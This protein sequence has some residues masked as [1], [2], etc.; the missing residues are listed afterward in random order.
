[1]DIIKKRYTHRQHS[2]PTYMNRT[3]AHSHRNPC[4][5]HTYNTDPLAHG[6]NTCTNP[7][8]PTRKHK[9]NT[10]NT[11]SLPSPP[12]HYTANTYTYALHTYTTYKHTHT[13]HTN[14]TTRLPSPRHT[15]ATA[16]QTQRNPHAKYS[17]HTQRDKRNHH[18]FLG[19]A[20]GPSKRTTA[21][22]SEAV[23]SRFCRKRSLT[24]RPCDHSF[25]IIIKFPGILTVWISVYTY[26]YTYIE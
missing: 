26:I 4:I 12:A 23:T 17:T 20:N 6:H 14:K 9:T 21:P 15:Y 18:Q 19:A 2:L 13:P 1:M 16:T 25:R 24:W 11:N 10:L 7:H 8:S 5:T 3:H 22:F